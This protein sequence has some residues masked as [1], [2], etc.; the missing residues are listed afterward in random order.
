[1]QM[2][3]TWRFTPRW[4]EHP[5]LIG[6]FFWESFLWSVTLHALQQ[7]Q[8]LKLGYSSGWWCRP[9]DLKH[10][11]TQPENCDSLAGEE[12]G[13]LWGPYPDGGSLPLC[14]QPALLLELSSSSPGRFDALETD[15][16]E[17]GGDK[18]WFN[19]ATLYIVS[20]LMFSLLAGYTQL[21]IFTISPTVVPLPSQPINGRRHSKHSSHHTSWIWKHHLTPQSSR[22]W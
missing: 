7:L 1:M 16:Q 20:G 10:L 17:R 13:E 3:R 8:H 15:V 12:S 6:P 9:E 14:G 11:R 2:R 21:Q 5:V 22:T 19:Q 18:V 4:C